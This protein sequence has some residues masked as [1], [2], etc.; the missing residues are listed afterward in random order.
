M[1]FSDFEKKNIHFFMGG[2]HDFF[3]RRRRKQKFIR[4]S[5]QNVNKNNI[6]CVCMCVLTWETAKHAK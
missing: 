3:V 2:A 4:S 5:R 6:L 1:D